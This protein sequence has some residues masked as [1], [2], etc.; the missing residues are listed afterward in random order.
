[1]GR[2]FRGQDPAQPPAPTTGEFRLEDDGGSGFDSPMSDVPSGS[3]AASTVSLNRPLGGPALGDRG[4]V[5]S[6]ALAAASHVRAATAATD[7]GAQAGVLTTLRETSAATRILLSGVFV[8]QLGA[9]MQAFL[10]LYL[11]HAGLA[12]GQAGFALGAY[13]FGAILGTL[14]GGEVADRMGQRPTIVASMTSV[15]LLTI[16]VSFLGKVQTYV[17][18]LIVVAATGAMTQ[19]S[20]TAT[21]AMLADL[22]PTARRVMVFS[23]YRIALNLGGVMGP[24]LAA[25]LVS[26]SW[27]LLFWADGLT[28]LA[29]AAVAVLCLPRGRGT[30]AEAAP[31]PDDAQPSASYV[32]VLRDG[33]F[34][35]YLFA[36]FAN[37]LIYV[38]YF[39]VLPLKIATGPY[40]TV[41]Y[42]WVLALSA[43][44][45]VTCE[46]LVTRHVQ[47]W[48]PARAASAGIVLLGV[49]LAAYGLQGGVA[50]LLA[51]TIIGVLGQMISGPTMLAHPGKVAPAG[52]KGRY[53]GAGNAMF[54]LGG[55]IGA[56]AGV[57]LW[58]Y[59]GDG[60]WAVC[61]VV[62]GFSAAAAAVGLWASTPPRKQRESQA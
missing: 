28:S 61:G 11:V 44:L 16:C 49:G 33:R 60:I 52:A 23:M 24:L 6:A 30:A 8:N 10:V 15:A 9:F 43:G 19:A 56:P 62:A 55:A 47:A 20:R 53:I 37:V 50:L 39:S 31:A 42:N 29:Y 4:A 32:A 36:M 46:L 35:L 58:N 13:G 25:W 57:L 3:R 26:V 21:A 41:A 40:P 14:F 1:M 51:A 48:R 7:A 18:L 22:T 27:D 12:E 34:L 2:C 59:L 17:P 5:T 38:Q 45:V 54:G